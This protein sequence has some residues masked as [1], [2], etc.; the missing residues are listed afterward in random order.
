[1]RATIEPGPGNLGAADLAV[2]AAPPNGFG[3]VIDAGVV[4]GGGFVQR[5]PTGDYI[6]ALELQ[7]GQVGIKAIGVLSTGTRLVAADA[8]LRPVPAGPARLRLHAGRDRRPDRGA[9]GGRR[10]Q[11]IIG[12][13]TGRSTTSLFPADPV[14]DAPRIIARLRPLFPHA[15]RRADDRPDGRPAL[16]QAGDHHGAA[17]GADAARQRARWGP[18]ALSQGRA[19]RPPAHRHRP[20]RGGPRRPGPAC[21]SSTSSASG[22]W[23]R[24]ATASSPRCATPA[25]PVSTSPAAWPCGASTATTRVP[26]RGGRLQPPLQG[27]AARWAARSTGSARPS[28]SAGST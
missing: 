11:L 8:A 2:R 26:A 25:S 14:S 21:S 27:R 12:M 6:G 13:R 20:D 7:F 22:T 18:A 4:T 10:P 1:M 16:G 15:P 5:D 19:R 28:R 3:V 9:A 24:S 23:P 17:G